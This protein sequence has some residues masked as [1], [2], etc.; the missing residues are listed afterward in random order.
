M[1][2]LLA[3]NG[4]DDPETVSTS[5]NLSRVYFRQQKWDLGRELMNPALAYFQKRPETSPEVLAS[6][7]E[8]VGAAE[9][10]AKNDKAA[11]P[12]L[13]QA[14]ERRKQVSG[15][16]HTR[17]AAVEERLANVLARRNDFGDAKLLALHAL[18][19]RR[20]ASGQELGLTGLLDILGGAYLAENDH[21]KALETVKEAVSIVERVRGPQD[22]MLGPFLDVLATEHVL[23]GQTDEGWTAFQRWLEIVKRQNTKPPLELA[24][25]LI[26]F[27]S[28][29]AKQGEFRRAVPLFQSGLD[30][31]QR[32]SG[33]AELDEVTRTAMTQTGAG[34]LR[35]A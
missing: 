35:R 27:G 34:L 24:A 3:L 18:S 32:E 6:L 2:L 25:R 26:Q 9:V 23:V 14:L 17:T 10:S 13:R 1:D 21:K 19:V 7:F 12:L 31:R 20:A 11:E 15:A 8:E 16:D 4:P 30:I 29:L 28:L 22:E 33:N 5:V